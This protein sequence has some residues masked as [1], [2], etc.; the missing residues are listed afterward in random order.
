M[1]SFTTILIEDEAMI[2]FGLGAIKG[3]GESIIKII[4][5]ARQQGLLRT[6]WIL[7]S[8]RPKSY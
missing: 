2:R 4:I 5:D 6:C 1:Y 8:G 7:F 3:V